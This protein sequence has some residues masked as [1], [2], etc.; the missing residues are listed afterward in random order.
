MTLVNTIR[1]RLDENF[2]W[3][4]KGQSPGLSM[5]CNPTAL[6]GHDILKPKDAVQIQPPA[7]LPL[8]PGDTRPQ[9]HR[10]YVLLLFQSHSE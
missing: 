8:V 7:F 2:P 4:C 3:I 10:S 5:I 1:F 6:C 9:K